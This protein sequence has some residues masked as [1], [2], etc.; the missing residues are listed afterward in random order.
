MRE[1]PDLMLSYGIKLTTR[2]KRYECCC[3]VHD[4][5]TSGSMSVYHNGTKWV[6]HC[7]VCS[8][9]HHDAYDFIQEMEGCGFKRAENILEGEFHKVTE[10]RPIP[11]K[12]TTSPDWH[13]F[14]ATEPPDSFTIRGLEG[15]TASWQYRDAT[16][17][18]LGYVCRYIKDGEKTYRPWTYGR[19]GEV[20]APLEWAARIW[21]KPRPLYGLDRLAVNPKGKVLLVEGE[22]TADAGQALI[23]AMICVTWPGGAQAIR[24]IDWTPLRGRDV[25][26]CPDADAP[27]EAAMKQVAAYLLPL[28]CCVKLIDSSDMPVGWDLADAEGWDTNQ[29]IQWARERLKEVTSG[30]IEA[31]KLKRDKEAM[32]KK[33]ECDAEIAPPPKLELVAPPPPP[34]TESIPVVEGNVVKMRDVQIKENMPEQFSDI[35]LADVWAQTGGKDWKYVATWNKWIR[36]DG[37][38]WD[39][40]EVQESFGDCLDLMRRA[41][42][43]DGSGN[44]STS[45]KREICGRGKIRSVL[46]VSGAH[47]DIRARPSDWDNDPFL[48]GTPNGTVNL[49]TGEIRKSERDDNITKHTKVAP[50]VGPMPIWEKVLDR[51]T[52][53]DEEMRLYYQKWAGYTLTGSTKE[54]AF[55]FIFGPQ[56]SGKSKFI[57]CIADILGSYRAEASIETFMESKMARHP[58]EIAALAG[59]RMV[60]CTEPTAGMRWN[61]GL[62]K[63]ITGR[64]KMTAS[65]KYEHQFEFTMQGKIWI[66]GNDKPHLGSADGME[67][68]IHIANFPKSIPDSEKLE[69]LPELL[70]K[71]WPAILQWAIDGCLLWQ[72]E[73]LHRPKQ[74]KQAVSE[75]IDNQDII[76]EWLQEHTEPSLTDRV[77]QTELYKS[78][79]DYVKSV[80]HGAVGNARLGP[81]LL[82]R[83]YKQVK[84]SG[85]RYVTGLRL[86]TPPPYAGN[87][88]GD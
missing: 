11:E 59:V 73:G 75:Y 5:K 27:G 64:E 37:N 54:E 32:E 47:K 22:K 10:L 17:Q 31:E 50:Q 72:K 45:Q 38:R 67:R 69:D 86:I 41:I 16:G 39:V 71:E 79:A 25:I 68:R 23:P 28:G 13:A 56:Q 12:L 83:G 87:R 58:E 29:A 53:G 21:H 15:P 78:Y 80:G 3:Y 35:H 1:L 85:V 63:K 9:V 4:D 7:F 33:T 2:G 62:M 49:R 55:L 34:E 65:R 77:K 24:H 43:W 74:V 82:K 57:G 18:I 26:L 66:S 52:D 14:P 48:L 70:E 76:G 19:I 60:T 51:C 6:A 42:H 44:L 40:D 20:A 84:T 36:W 81:E 88:Y 61:E 8:D 30:E 46:A